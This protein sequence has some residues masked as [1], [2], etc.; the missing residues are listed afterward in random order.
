[1]TTPSLYKTAAT[2]VK[3]YKLNPDDFPELQSIISKNSSYYFIARA[4]RS[5]THNDYIPIFK[6]EDLFAN[7]PRMLLDL[8]NELMK[9]GHQT[10]A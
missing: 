3:D 9:K 5:A 8:V 4:F 7:N 2:F 1:M 6:V 10:K